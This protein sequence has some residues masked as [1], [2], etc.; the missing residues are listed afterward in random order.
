MYYFATKISDNFYSSY[1][2]N[3]DGTS[4][5]LKRC[6]S[7]CKTCEDG[8]ENDNC[9]ECNTDYLFYEGGGRKCKPKDVREIDGIP[10]Y[11]NNILNE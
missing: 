6:E 1:Y 4:K 11:K 2:L 5:I 7:S 3:I 10:Y 8:N 9:K